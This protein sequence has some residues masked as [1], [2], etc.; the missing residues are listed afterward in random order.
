MIHS[1]PRWTAVL[2]VSAVVLTLSGCGLEANPGG[3]RSTQTG[4]LACTSR[5]TPD[6]S[7]YLYANPRP[8]TVVVTAP[9]SSAINN[10]EFFWSPSSPI[11]TDLTVCATFVSGQGLDQQGVVL[12]LHGL[13]NGR[14][15]G[16][17]VTRNVWAWAFD[18][19]NYHVWNTESDPSSP[20]TQFG[21]TIVS[22][23]P[24]RPATY[25]LNLCARTVTSTN[26]VQFVVW[27]KGQAMPTWGSAL[28][29]GEAVI[30]AGAPSSGRGGWFAGHLRPGTSMRYDNLSVDG[31]IQIDLPDEASSR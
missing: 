11:G 25:P 31:V 19:F 20:F 29:G 5:V 13:T 15:S 10:R 1:T 3:A 16:I 8:G 23:L 18:V 4:S 17:T 22:F 2:L 28:Q 12:R 21:S 26:Q 30:P 24:V 6:C 7:G 27:T 9:K 14:V